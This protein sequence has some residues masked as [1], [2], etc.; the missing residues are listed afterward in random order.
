MIV[1]DNVVYS[2]YVEGGSCCTLFDDPT[3]TVATTQA[4][5]LY[6]LLYQLEIVE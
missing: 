1:V 5:V 6:V 2:K 4:F 3:S